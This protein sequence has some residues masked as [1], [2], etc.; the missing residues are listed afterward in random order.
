M[1]KHPTKVS[2]IL[3][4]LC[5]YPAEFAGAL[6]KPSE[7]NK[8]PRTVLVQISWRNI[9]TEKPTYCRKPVCSATAVRVNLTLCF[10]G[11]VKQHTSMLLAP[12]STSSCTRVASSA[13][14]STS[15]ASHASIIPTSSQ[16]HRR[17]GLPTLHF[18]TSQPRQSCRVRAGKGSC[19]F[20]VQ[21]Q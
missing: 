9:S 14:A 10:S 11:G 18:Y 17:S 5:V 20:P 3:T 21:P 6:G 2:L 13:H 19:P 4:N 7:R 8:S 16:R 12:P 1:Y 15:G